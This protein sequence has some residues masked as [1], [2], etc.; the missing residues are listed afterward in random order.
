MSDPRDEA[1]AQPFSSLF[2]GNVL[3][4]GRSPWPA[5]CLAFR[6]CVPSPHSTDAFW[7]VTEC[8][9]T[10]GWRPGGF[11]QRGPTLGL[12]GPRGSLAAGFQG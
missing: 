11:H 7:R 4:P 12:P 9:L 5:P 10:P 8:L 6:V 1:K 2:P 3:W